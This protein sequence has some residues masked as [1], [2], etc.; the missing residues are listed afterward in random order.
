[1][2]SAGDGLGGARFVHGLWKSK[3]LY[4]TENGCPADDPMVNGRI[5]DAERIIDLPNC[6]GHFQR[7]T[8]EGLPL[9]D[10]SM[11]RLMDNFEGSDGYGK[12]FG[13]HYVDFA[14]KNLEATAIGLVSYARG[15]A[16]P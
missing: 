3:T 7:A 12:R 9:K 4:I 5:D 2:G 8:R 1:M 11:W 16:T 15:V 10:Y 14:T 13:V 6:L